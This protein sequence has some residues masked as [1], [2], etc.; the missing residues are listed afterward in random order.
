MYNQ[1]DGSQIIK[2][3]SLTSYEPKKYGYELTTLNLGVDPQIHKVY[4]QI[5]D[6]MV[7]QTP[8]IKLSPVL[9]TRYVPTF[10]E[11]NNLNISSQTIYLDEEGKIVSQSEEGTDTLYGQGQLEL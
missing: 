2:R 8:Q 3:A 10:F 9:N 11:N 5:Q 1:V 6:G 7:I 4:N